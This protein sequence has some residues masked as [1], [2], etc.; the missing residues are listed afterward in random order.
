MKAKTN[1]PNKTNKTNKDSKGKK[2][3]KPS[4][5]KPVTNKVKP[6]ILRKRYD[7]NTFT[8][9]EIYDLN[10]VYFYLIRHTSN[11]LRRFEKM[12]MNKGLV[13]LAYLEEF[14]RFDDNK[15]PNPR[16]KFNKTNDDLF[17]FFILDKYKLLKNLKIKR[18]KFGVG[19]Q[20]C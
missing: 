11:N 1:K 17:K 13:D 15:L 18:K 12:M 8:E 14:M 5:V 19:E 6:V 16:M 2:P 7:Q 10:F 3:K 9:D 20:I 4:K